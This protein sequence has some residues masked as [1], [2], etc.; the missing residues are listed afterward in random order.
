MTSAK[1]YRRYRSSHAPFLE[2]N[3]SQD[4]SRHL[5]RGHRRGRSR[6]HRGEK[7]LRRLIASNGRLGLV[8]LVASSGR[9]HALDR[10]AL[11]ELRRGRDVV[12]CVLGLGVGLWDV[13]IEPV[14][15]RERRERGRRHT[16]PSPWTMFWPSMGPLSLD[17]SPLRGIVNCW[18]VV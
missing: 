10:T 16:L 8:S 18:L 17:P 5:R 1:E 12:L 11:L 15:V 3:P 2:F 13:S 7:L 4:S 14:E 9:V 6:V